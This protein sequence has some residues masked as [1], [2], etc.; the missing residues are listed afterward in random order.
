MKLLDVLFWSC[1]LLACQSKPTTSSNALDLVSTKKSVTGQVA[2][3]TNVLDLIQLKKAGAF[4][5]TQR[6]TVP[7]DPVYHAR[8]VYRAVPLN[9]VLEQV[10]GYAQANPATTQ[11]VFECGDGYNPSMPLKQVLGR[12]AFLAVRDSDAPAGQDWIGVETTGKTKSV[13][14]FYIVY[15]DVSATD[16]RYKWPY[17]LV[18]IRLVS[19]SKELAALLPPDAPAR[20]YELFRV[21]CLTC[22]ALNGIGGQMGPELN[23]PKNITEYWWEADIVA[24]VRN[25]ASYRNGVKMPAITP[26]QV[27]NGELNEVL[28]YLKFMAGHKSRS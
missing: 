9:K 21:H 22:H 18:R 1:W 2:S 15:T 5:T 24:F 25:P 10:P 19:A 28:K 17:N 26:T 4:G 12:R 13:A 3:D 27:S 16:A 7:Q 23:F 14:P 20:G 11:V 6:I 8:K